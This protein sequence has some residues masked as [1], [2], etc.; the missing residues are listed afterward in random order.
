MRS[1]YMFTLVIIAIAAIAVAGCS[2][3]QPAQAIPQPTTGTA[4]D[5]ITLVSTP[6]G[7]VLADA[8]GR[9]LY[10][11]ITDVPGSGASTCYGTCAAIWPV[12]FTDNV[13][14]PSSLSAAD[15]S[16]I[17]RTDGTK[18]TTFRGWPLYY[19]QSDSGPGNTKGEGVLNVWYVARPDYTVMVTDRPATGSYLTDGTGRT[20]YFFAKDSNGTSACTGACPAKWPPFAPA[21]VVA[22]SLLKV[23]DFSTISRADGTPQTTYMGRPLYYFANDTNPGDMNGNGFNNLWY[24]ANITGMVPAVMNPATTLTTV[25]TAMQSAGGGY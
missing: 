16:S 7:N 23:S 25:T 3:Q 17:T 4:A 14:V 9:T 8:N 5:T 1:L 18:E 2:Q 19:Y 24:V 12:F 20:L 10:Y 6:I 21:S 15:F 11:F 22:P 13:V